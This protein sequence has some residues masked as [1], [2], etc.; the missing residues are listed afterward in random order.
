MPWG[1]A[2]NDPTIWG[3]IGQAVLPGPVGA[4]VNFLSNLVTSGQEKRKADEAERSYYSALSRQKQLAELSMR[5]AKS[6]AAYEETLKNRIMSQ[7]GELGANLRSAQKAMGAMPQFN[8]TS[9]NKTYQDNRERMLTDFNQMLRIVESQGRAA[10]AER[11]GGAGSMAADDTRMTALIRQYAPELDKIDNNAYEAAVARETAKMGLFNTS[12]QNTLKEISDVLSPQITAE[13]QLLGT[14][15]NEIQTSNQI[16]SGLTNELY[17]LSEKTAQGSG[18]ASNNTSD[19]LG[20]L[21]AE[22]YGSQKRPGVRTP[23]YNPNAGA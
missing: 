12:R 3:T 21:L 14:G 10:Q 9:V 1:D 7:T 5:I 16:T 15:P 2:L 18:N 4:G 20:A 8:E 19:A 17:G 23:S 13:T 11:L 22:L 6:R